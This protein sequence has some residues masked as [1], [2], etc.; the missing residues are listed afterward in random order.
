LA[1][2]IAYSVKHIRLKERG[3]WGVVTDAAYA[4]LIPEIILLV[5]IN[6]F[7][8]QFFVPIFFLL[9]SF[10]IGVRDI[11]IHQFKD[12]EN[13][14]KSHT[15]TFVSS[16]PTKASGYI[17]S[18]N[19]AIAAFTLLLAVELYLVTDLKYMLI[20]F[21]ALTIVFIIIIISGAYKH[22]NDAYIRAYIICTSLLLGFMLNQSKLYIGFVF[23][24]HPYI[25]SFLRR[26]VHALYIKIKYVTILFLSKLLLTI[27]PLALNYIIFLI[28]KIISR[29]LRKKPLYNK[30]QEPLL[31]KNFRLRLGGKK[32]K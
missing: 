18:L 21:G 8:N 32:I 16:Q 2:L 4:H 7:S 22:L 26:N 28:F 12:Y 27:I 29:D 25:L 19:I 11:L 13:D 3:F 24:L 23:L 17:N 30:Q 5:L 31:M 14:K 9:L 15:K 6:K 1:L 20:L 10:S